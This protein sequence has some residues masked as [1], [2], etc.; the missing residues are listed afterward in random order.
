MFILA[1]S[2]RRA[3]RL[4]DGQ[5]TLGAALE[6]RAR[7]RWPTIPLGWGKKPGFPW[8]LPFLTEAKQRRRREARDKGCRLEERLRVLVSG[9]R[10]PGLTPVL[11]LPLMSYVAVGNK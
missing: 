4:G 1:L 6:D 9:A 5:M 11:L 8:S 2:G 3:W 7:G 10:Q